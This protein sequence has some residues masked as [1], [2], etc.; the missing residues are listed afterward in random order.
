MTL[1][2]VANHIACPVCE[3]CVCAPRPATP[4]L[5]CQ[6]AVL[7]SV[8]GEDMSKESEDLCTQA[9]SLE[10]RLVCST[11]EGCQLSITRASGQQRSISLHTISGVCQCTA[12]LM[13]LQSSISFVAFSFPFSAIICGRLHPALV[14]SWSRPGNAQLL[15][16]S[17]YLRPWS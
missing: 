13:S 1:P 2:D 14:N 3:G 5:C 4:Q 6:T 10:C 17:W 11:S 8:H 16:L 7:A 9:D 15:V 12:Y